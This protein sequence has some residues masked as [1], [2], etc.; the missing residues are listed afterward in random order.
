MRLFAVSAL[1]LATLA[2]PAFAQEA[3]TFTGPRAEVVAGWDHVGGNGEGASGFTYGGALGYDAQLGSAVLGAE[4]E[5]TGATTDRDGVSAGRDLYVG[6]RIGFVAMPNTLVYAKGGL[7]NARVNIDTFGGVNTDGYR[8][9]GGVEH[10]FG[11]F[12]GKVEYRY[13]RYEELDLN[14]DQV[15]AGIGIR[16]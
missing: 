12:Y 16:F 13:S 7:T 3:S 9:G 2:T 4:V 8:F 14:R 6:G 15:L 1:A 11:G 10:D 5:V